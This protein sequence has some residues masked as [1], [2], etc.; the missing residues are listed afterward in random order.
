LKARILKLGS[1]KLPA[2]QVAAEESAAF[3]EKK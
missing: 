2:M 1:F 3:L